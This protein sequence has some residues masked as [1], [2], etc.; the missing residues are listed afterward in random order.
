M[1]I[2][3]GPAVALVVF[4]ISTVLCV[5]WT[6]IAGKDL[7]WD[8]LHYHYYDA[9]ALLEWRIR[10][11]YFAASTQSYLNPLGYVPFYLMVSA[12]WHSALVS[13]L[14]AAVHGTSLTLLF[15]IGWIL[16]AHRAPRERL[17]ASAFAAALGSAS[18]VFWAT[19]GTSFLDPLLVVPML[20]GV[21]LMIGARPENA[22]A[23]AGWAGILF[24]A[25]AALK[26]SNAFFALAAL[27]LAVTMPATGRPAR[28]RALA[29]YIGGGAVST[30][31]LAGPWLATMYR[32]FGN[33]FFPHLNAIFRSPD[34]PPI[35][36]VA[37]RYAPQTLWEVLTFPFRLVSHSSM[38]YAEISAPDLRIAALGVFAAALGVAVALRRRHAPPDSA[39]LGTIENRLL[40]FF[41]L[42][43]LLWIL[44]SANGRYGMF[45]LLLAGPC[46]ARLADR[47]MPFRGASTVI[48]IMLGVQIL[49]CVNVSTARWFVS[50]RWSSD[51]FPFLAP[52]RARSTPALYFTVE[53]QA[54]G[55]VVPFLHPG[56]SFVNLRGQHSLTSGRNRV[57]D[58]LA[59]HSGNV[60][61]LG[62]ALRAGPYGAPRQDVIDAYD[63]T[64]M[65]FGF[66]I[67]PGDCFT[68]GW[69][70][71]GDDRLSRWANRVSSE[72]GSRER[73]M[74]LGSC[75]LRKAMRDPREIDEER[76]ISVI[77]DRIERSCPRLFRGQTSVTERLGG[78]WSRDYVGLEARMETHSGHVVLVPYFKL[79]YVHLGGLAEWDRDGAPPPACRDAD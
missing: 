30:T 46:L 25:G 32:E 23:R 4:C 64:L 29:A 72:T 52:E 79:K 26:Y 56:S 65:R 70:P 22:V 74:S 41:A 9:H 36:L 5:A 31:V 14:L 34:F 69:R 1:R 2:H 44:T 49:A 73:I 75:A 28:M 76:R 10:Q 35:N 38:T 78:E 68:I 20:A 66:R 55:A 42:A 3:A 62:R 16:F 13:M 48:L 19:V 47:L 18:A 24:G 57:G 51:W 21:L 27:L 45:V 6:L 71:E 37:A 15:C 58:L 50:E 7:N 63:S 53:A 61:V 12:G 8:L 43:L 17:I 77:F 39:A 59:R 60:R 33:P 11:D 67:D 40:A 54:M